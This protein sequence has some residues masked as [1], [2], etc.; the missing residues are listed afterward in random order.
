MNLF[1]QPLFSKKGLLSTFFALL[2][3]AG[4]VVTIVQVQ[5]Q[6][7]IRQ[8]AAPACGTPAGSFGKCQWTEV[9]GAKSYIVT[10]KDDS[11][12]IAF[13]PNYFL[14]TDPHFTAFP[15]EAGK[16][17]T[18]EVGALADDAKQCGGLLG[19]GTSTICQG[20]ANTPTPSP[21]GVQNPTNT[22]VPTSPPGSTP[23]PTP[24]KGPTPT[25]TPTGNPTAT[26]T[27]TG[28]P[29]PTKTPTPTP[30]STPIPT[31]TATP[32]PPTAIPP[33]AIPPT[34][35]VIVPTTPPVV[36]ATNIPLP[37][38]TPRPTIV[39]T[40]DFGKSIGIVS[41]IVITLIGG[42]LLLAL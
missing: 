1:N 35:V 33:T 2:L 15:A 20:L 19:R 40:G 16:K 6:Q 13:G 34:G 21:T 25:P 27:P 4:L 18:C 26:P 3:I 42:I 12:N 36:I 32:V 38:N 7:E 17:Y 14:Q 5:K 11:G 28:A 9:T 23:T 39:P 41:V 37:T 8:R 24:T 22:P 29:T 10:V 31:A 30:T